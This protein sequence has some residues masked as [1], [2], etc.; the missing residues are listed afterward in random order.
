MQLTLIQ[1]KLHWENTDRNLDMLAG[2][3]EA[4]SASDLIV[5]PEM[6]TTGFSMRPEELASNNEH[7][8]EWCRAQAIKSNAAICGS[9]MILSD[10]KYYNRLFFAQPDGKVFTYNKKHL[11]T[12]AGEQKTYTAGK[13]S[14][15]IT[16]KGWRIKPLICYDLRFPVWSRN[17]EDYDLLLYVANWPERR[18]EAWS[19]LLKARS[20]ENMCYTVGLNRV[21]LDGNDINYDGSSAV[22]DP[23][24]KCSLALE[25]NTECTASIKLDK[26]YLRKQRERFGFLKDRDQFEL[27][28]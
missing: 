26:D 10:A 12:L 4:A 6:F 9:A 22:Y 11:F 17:T 25:K 21:G 24:G 5:L 13:E 19:S 3:I 15:L 14:L 27:L 7:I 23:L 1:T 18:V 20:I 16:Y 8:E 2:K 28:S